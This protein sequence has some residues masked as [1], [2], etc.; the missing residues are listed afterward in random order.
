VTQMVSDERAAALRNKCLNLAKTCRSGSG[1]ASERTSQS[2]QLMSAFGTFR[3]R[4]DVRYNR[5]SWEINGHRNMP[6]SSRPRQP[7]P[8]DGLGSRCVIAGGAERAPRATLRDPSRAAKGFKSAEPLPV[9][10]HHVGRRALGAALPMHDFA[11]DE[12]HRAFTNQ[13]RRVD[14]H[15]VSDLIPPQIAVRRELSLHR[16]HAVDRSHRVVIGLVIGAELQHAGGQRFLRAET[17]RATH[18][19]AGTVCGRGRFDLCIGRT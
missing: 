4:R 7:R 10:D 2:R 6:L 15:Q 1:P 14:R 9:R 11:D 19:L 18:R 13:H 8:R 17:H 12:L 5:R 16:H 3:T